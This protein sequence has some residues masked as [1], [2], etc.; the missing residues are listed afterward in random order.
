LSTVCARVSHHRY[1]ASPIGRN[2]HAI[3][4]SVLRDSFFHSPY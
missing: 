4:P 1:R 3:I 2:N